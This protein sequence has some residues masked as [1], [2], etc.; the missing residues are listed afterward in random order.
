MAKTIPRILGKCIDGPLHG[1]FFSVHEDQGVISGMNGMPEEAAYIKV[2]EKLRDFTGEEKALVG[3]LFDTDVHV[4]TQ[5]C[6]FKYDD[7]YFPPTNPNEPTG[8][9]EPTE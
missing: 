2:S 4:L 1:T 3:L 8:P 7:S 9:D 5:I 6:E